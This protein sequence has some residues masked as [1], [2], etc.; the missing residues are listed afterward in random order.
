[1]P[2]LMMKKMLDLNTWKSLSRYITAVSPVLHPADP[3]A[4]RK[5]SKGAA[6]TSDTAISATA[7]G[8]EENLSG[9]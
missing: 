6:R 5:K 3:K 9:R 1:M 7:V 4:T 2:G 8:T